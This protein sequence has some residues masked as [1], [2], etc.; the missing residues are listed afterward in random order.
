MQ[1]HWA[2]KRG[3]HEAI[4]RQL[5]RGQSIEAL[6][7]E[8]ETPLMLASESRHAGVA[9]LELLVKAGADV[10]A[11]SV[12]LGK[13]PLALAARAGDLAKVRYLLEAGADPRFVNRSGYTAITNVPAGRDADQLAV[14]E[15]LL[16]AGADPN[17]VSRYGECPLRAATREGNFEA[18]RMLLRHG[19]DRAP[20][21]FN[22]LMWAIAIGTVEDVASELRRRADLAARDCWEMTP[23][24]LSLLTGDIAKAGLL[25]EAG[26]DLNDRGRC[27][28]T[29]LMYPV[30]CNHVEMTRWLLA[31]GVDSNACDDTGTPP[32]A[33]AE[34]G[35]ADCVRLLL[36]AG[37][38]PGQVSRFGD[39]AVTT[40]HDAATLRLLV[41]AGAD[42]NAVAGDGYCLLKRA[43]EEGDA[44]LVQAILGLGADVDTTSTGD[45]A[46][47][48]A[49]AWDQ[50]DIVELLLAHGTDPNAQD[51][52]GWTPLMFAG[53][54]ECVELLLGAGADVHIADQMG[55]QVLRHH[56]D[57]EIL[58][59][60]LQA[61]ADFE[62]SAG[63]CGTALHAA[64]ESGDLAAARYLL[65]Q[66]ANVNATTI[67]GQTP[68]MEAAERGHADLL[69]L[70]LAAGADVSAADEEGRTALFYAAAPEGFTA[71]ELAH[72]YSPEDCPEDAELRDAL[73]RQGIEI[74]APDYG[75]RPSDDTAVL[76][77][78]VQAGA[79]LEARDAKGLTPLLLAARCGRPARVAALVRLGANIQ[80][81]DRR[82]RS[83]V[84]QTR[85]HHDPDQASEIRRLLGRGF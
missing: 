17:V 84:R 4:H 26:A 46:L 66:G 35:A 3:D 22:D 40:A 8:G 7:G 30:S 34:S 50:L 72:E 20:A 82:W 68:L 63:S 52:D 55:A 61:G 18:V 15:L 5:R 25:L 36:E 53:S 65:A 1:I 28:K 58:G 29:A 80:A 71:F 13:T 69:R 2:A 33:A 39:F 73:T 85:R 57:T 32:M 49:V 51:V 6:D 70:F 41:A 79:D 75:Y 48:S 21:G 43:A 24:L 42:I 14:L 67:W 62:G 10:N 74:P 45:T 11:V 37:A 54:L 78:L 81:R 76:E 23:W 19:A 47:H 77:M 9:T 56:G 27:G 64:C 16:E 38:N 83:A 59:R 60:L 12:E 44:E 31:L